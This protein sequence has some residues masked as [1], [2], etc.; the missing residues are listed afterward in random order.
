[1]GDTVEFPVAPRLDA[2]ARRAVIWRRLALLGLSLA[3][4]VPGTVGVSF[5]DRDEGWYAQVC[6]EMLAT[7][8]WLIPRY[9][10]EPW[11]GKP[12][13]LYW[14][15]GAA[16][17]AL[18]LHEWAARGVSVISMTLATQLVYSLGLRTYGATAAWHGAL[19]FATAGLPVFLG[20]ML[21]T[22]ALL[23]VWILA[24]ARLLLDMVQ[25][26]PTVWRSLLLW[27]C[28]GLGTLTK[29]PVIGLFLAPLG[30]A[31]VLTSPRA[32]VWRSTAFWSGTLAAAAI[33][34]PWFV[35][36]AWRAPD[37]FWNQLVGYEIA[38][39]LVSAPH[40]HTGP[41]GFY[42]LVFFAG[43]L[44]WSVLWPGAVMEAAA[45]IRTD[46]AARVLLAWLVVPWLIL[47]FLPSKLV[48]Y[49]LPCYA[50]LAI[51]MGRMWELGVGR[52]RSRVE[53]AVAEVWTNVPVVA[54]AALV[55]AALALRDSDDLLATPHVLWAMAA[56]GV[57]LAGPALGALAAVRG[58]RMAAA[59]RWMTASAAAFHL[60]L[61]GYLLPALEP[62]RLSRRVAEAANG[63][64][65][66]RVI[67]GDYREPTLFF[68]LRGRVELGDVEAVARHEALRG[69]HG[70]PYE[71]TEAAAE[72]RAADGGH[73]PPEDA[74]AVAVIARRAPGGERPDGATS[75]AG[76][77]YATGDWVEVLVFRRGE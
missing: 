3:V 31:L 57:A 64:D 61:G 11:L 36:A 62:H 52:Q 38:S 45:R 77:N 16:F 17:G 70:P 29:G 8:D 65:A 72:G 14:L 26:G 1:M 7:G 69:G 22:D 51:L 67:V 56:A 49:A 5:F 4:L 71:D 50:P 75:V 6:R 63:L 44:P 53:C 47:E 54:G 42:L 25:Q 18:G 68:Y 10:G 24:A 41:P 55:C 2:E 15:A 13:L 28:V 66:P 60:T 32:A 73:G 21:I 76:F 33:A 59:F 58:G 35:L 34:G 12:P 23:L 46:R 27:S 9:L 19:I 30:V 48:H 40:G 43:W 20:R 37:A 74:E 39:R